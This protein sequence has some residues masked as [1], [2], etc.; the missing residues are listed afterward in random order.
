MITVPKSIFSAI[1]N[2]QNPSGVSNAFAAR[3]L[4]VI[5]N[6]KDNPKIFDRYGQWNGIGTIFFTRL[7][8][9]NIDPDFTTNN[10]ARPLFANVKNYP[11]INEIVYILP[12]PN[13]NVQDNV[14][15][16]SYYYFNPINIWN[17]NHHNGIPDPINK[18][19]LPPSQQQDYI[20]TGLGA[21][22]RI[23]DGGSEIN[24]GITFKE[25]A[26]IKPQ[27]P[28][29][30]DIIYEGRWGQSIRFSSTIL[31]L[32]GSTPLNNWS[33][34]GQNGDPI[35]I[36]KNGQHNDG[37]DPWIPQT[38]QINLDTSSIYLT[39][40]QTIPITV[41]SELYNS[42]KEPPTSVKS[43]N[44]DQIILNSGRLLF[45]SKEDHI[46]LTSNKSI[47]LNSIQSVNV[48]T[49]DFA[50]NAKNVYLGDKNAT[51]P[52]ILG[53]IFLRDLTQLLKGIV[54]LSTALTTPIGTPAPYVPNAS[55]LAPAQSLIGDASSMLN[56]I[57]NYK[58]KVS[59]T[60]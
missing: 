24:L 41:A 57:Q 1:P 54:E 34:T 3:V 51:E 5:I 2:A 27:Q 19:T 50:V 47:N 13:S 23:T 40:T 35:V 25:K 45:N 17:S 53:D 55:I 33:S 44:K 30:G 52:V 9:P 37:K 49:S 18:N 56:N 59:K 58:S 11:L 6:N 10:F 46:L 26:N 39:S 28:Y 8:N 29:E 4:H 48:D 42:Y 20:Q 38:E 31:N 22:R 21:V 60:V 12:L 32:T 7:D 36:I 14:N 43:Y 15:D 16:I